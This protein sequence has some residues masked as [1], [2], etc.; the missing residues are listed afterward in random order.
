[1]AVFGAVGGT[2]VCLVAGMIGARAVLSAAVNDEQRQV[3]RQV[4]A[5]GSV[6]AVAVMGLVLLAAFG[7]VPGWAYAAA[8]V[9]WFG[10]LLPALAW[11][12]QRLDSAA[13][14]V[15]SSAV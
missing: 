3:L 12:H 13:G 11:V 6:H 7:V 2:M 4:L 10:P 8:T 15:A 1:M 14:A 5:F 9:L